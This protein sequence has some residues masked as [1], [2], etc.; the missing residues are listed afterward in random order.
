MTT[1]HF[2]EKFM[3]KTLAQF[4]D[5]HYEWVESVGWTGK[6]TA[7][8]NLGRIGSEIGELINECRGED[9][10][11][12]NFNEELADVI[13]ASITAVKESQHPDA[14]EDQEIWIIAKKRYESAYYPESEVREFSTLFGAVSYGF[15]VL[16]NAIK[17]RIRRGDSRIT[18]HRIHE[19]IAYFLAV[20]HLA[21]IDINKALTDKMEKNVIKGNRGRK[22]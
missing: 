7:L 17:E 5:E 15:V 9:A 19:I 1:T 13:L 18:V 11:S 20:A 22:K 8:E 4:A 14:F 16:G 21:G 10:T 3:E 6:R 2:K 12:E